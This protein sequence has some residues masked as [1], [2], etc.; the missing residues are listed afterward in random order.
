MIKLGYNNHIFANYRRK[1]L[2]TGSKLK[3]EGPKLN[4]MS[5]SGIWDIDG[6]N[7]KTN[8]VSFKLVAIFTEV[9]NEFMVFSKINTAINLIKKR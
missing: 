2:R 9:K 8:R 4:G 7:L 5:G 3:L 1:Y 6:Y